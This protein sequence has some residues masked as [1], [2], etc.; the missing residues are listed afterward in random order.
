MFAQIVV[1]G[2]CSQLRTSIKQDCQNTHVGPVHMYHRGL[3]INCKFIFFLVKCKLV[4]S[5][6]GKIPAKVFLDIGH[7]RDKGLP[8]LLR[9]LHL[10]QITWTSERCWSVGSWNSGNNSEKKIQ[11]SSQALR[12]PVHVLMCADKKGVRGRLPEPARLL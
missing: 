10:L 4:S 11:G 3:S 7:A 2:L 6:S 9:L 5:S 1:G 12:N 8:L